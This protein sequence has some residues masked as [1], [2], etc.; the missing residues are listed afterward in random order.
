MVAIIDM[1]AVLRMPASFI[2][3]PLSQKPD[4]QPQDDSNFLFV[5]ATHGHAS[6]G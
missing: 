5:L 1:T 2:I 3:L 4:Q 6:K